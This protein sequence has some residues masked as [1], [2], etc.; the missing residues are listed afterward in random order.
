MRPIYVL[1]CILAL[2]LSPTEAHPRRASVT[3]HNERSSVG[4]VDFVQLYDNGPVQLKG[5]IRSL[6]PGQ[7]GLNVHESGDVRNNSQAAGG[8]F[9]PWQ[10]YHG[11]RFDMERH[12]GDL[13]NIVADASGVAN[14]SFTDSRISLDGFNSIIG[15]TLVVHNG[16]DDLGRAGTD[17]SRKTGNSG[18]GVAYGVIG[19]QVTA[20]PPLPPYWP[21]CYPCPVTV[22]AVINCWWPSAVPC[23]VMYYQ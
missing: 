22:G 12:V 7:H 23:N 11:G 21:Y 2:V 16:T 9:N 10:R 13:G 20:L 3:L 14:F 6:T 8:H 1:S 5:T 4:Y 17:E 15:R 18:V 19:I